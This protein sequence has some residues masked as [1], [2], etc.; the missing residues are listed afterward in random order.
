MERE[1]TLSCGR[2]RFEQRKAM[3]PLQAP[4]KKRR[5]AEERIQHAVSDTLHW[6][7]ALRQSA[8]LLSRPHVAKL[9]EAS[10]ELYALQQPLLNVHVTEV[11]HAIAASTASHIAP[12]TL[13]AVLVRLDTAMRC[14]GAALHAAASR[15]GWAD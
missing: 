3:L 2:E 6:L 11:L 4:S 5:E 13:A 15:P 10:V 8:P 14:L 9:C 7:G 1:R 12:R